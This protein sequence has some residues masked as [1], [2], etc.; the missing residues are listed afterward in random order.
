M[1]SA[2]NA[3]LLEVLN[4][5]SVIAPVDLSTAANTGD[6]IN[7]S[8]YHDFM[9]VLFKGVGTAG[10]DPTITIEQATAAA[11]TGNKALK[12]TTLYTKQDTAL[13]SVG[14]WTEV[15]QAAANTYTDAT[16]AED[17]ALWA[18]PFNTD[19]LDID[20][21]FT[22]VQASVGDVG[23]NAQIGCAFIILGTPKYAGAPEDH[24]SILS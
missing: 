6:W 10:D 18:I 5:G 21:G 8:K 24:A 9:L 2:A 20:G 11:G 7:V 15:T 4:I 16:S 1:P 13:T 17:Q 14:T 22:H 3:K 23:T 19:E 12:F